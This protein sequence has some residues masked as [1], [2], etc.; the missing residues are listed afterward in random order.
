MAYLHENNIVMR[1]LKPQNIGFDEHSEVKLFDFG[2]ARHIDD[3]KPGELTGTLR[4]MAP[5]VMVGD[6][7]SFRAD[8]YSF[9][10]L[11]WE[12]CTCSLPFRELKAGFS[13]FVHK[14]T[15]EDV[16]PSL[17]KVPC[18]STRQLIEEC[19]DSD[20]T[21]RP[22][23]EE[24]CNR[25]ADITMEKEEDFD[26]DLSTKSALDLSKSAKTCNVSLTS[27]SMPEDYSTFD[28]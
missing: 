8:V 17:E 2:M 19:W 7:Y 5:E 28:P 18:E 20:Y 11:L 16:R 21:K 25:L 4:Y 12:I 6:A 15:Y 3:C 14:V 22:S 9:G 10:V 26:L 24:I 13:D 23:F 27:K 1:D